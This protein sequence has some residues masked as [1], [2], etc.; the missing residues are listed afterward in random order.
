MHVINHIISNLKTGKK[1]E[2][3]G[4]LNI[5]T[6]SHNSEIKCDIEVAHKFLHYDR[7]GKFVLPYPLRCMH[8]CWEFLFLVNIQTCEML[9][10][11]FFLCLFLEKVFYMYVQDYEYTL[12][13]MFQGRNECIEFHQQQR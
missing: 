1:E 12:R 4:L 8:G 11:I 6:Q 9:N 2:I 10:E 7:F 5:N 3:L 13:L